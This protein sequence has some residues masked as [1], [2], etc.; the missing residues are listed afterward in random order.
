MNLNR[1]SVGGGLAV[2][3]CS[4]FTL[5]GAISLSG[6]DRTAHATGGWRGAPW[7]DDDFA[8][9]GGRSKGAFEEATRSHRR[10]D[11]RRMK[12]DI[13]TSRLASSQCFEGEPFEMFGA[14]REI[15][16][17]N[18]ADA[19]ED[20]IDVN[21][22]GRPEAF[23][24]GGFY[25][26]LMYAGEPLPSNCFLALQESLFEKGEAS[27]VNRCVLPSERLLEAALSQSHVPNPTNAFASYE[28]WR[29]MDG[30]GDFDFIAG[31]GVSD[32]RP[33]AQAFS[34]YWFENIG[35]EATQPLVGDLD[36]DGAV[37]ASDLTMLL[38]GWTGS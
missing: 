37:G 38:G 6:S 25:W 14:M 31:I 21:A 29:D 13:L 33:G 28:G 10:P 1:M 8:G 24:D 3:G 34:L 17:C 22:D 7:G 35:I 23:L 36:G 19:G 26:S 16:D 2:L 32:G 18:V 11:R 12:S 5:A 9:V 4:I 30:D 27:F 15:S 20:I